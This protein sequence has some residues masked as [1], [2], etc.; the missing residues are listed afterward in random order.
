MDYANKTQAS[1]ALARFVCL[2]GLALPIF[3]I[4]SCTTSDVPAQKVA[5]FPVTLTIGLP[6]QTGQD[7]LYGASQA[8]RLLSREGLI[9]PSRDGRVQPRLAEQWTESADGLT[10]M[11]KLRANAFFHDG[12]PVEASDVKASLER[13]LKNSDRDLSPGLA[14]ITAIEVKESH[15]I[16]IRLA[17]RSTFLL[18]DLGV[19]I[20]KQT[21]NG[22]VATGPFTVQATSGTEVTMTAVP[23]HY[24]GK[25]SID[26]VVLKA[27][28]AV[29]TA[30]AAMMRGEVDFLY[31]VGPD[32]L[33]FIE[34]E[35]SVKVFPFLRNYVYALVFNS[36]RSFFANSRV[37]QALNFAVNRPTLVEHAFRGK[38]VAANGSAWPLHWAY[39]AS[40]PQY[41]Y[42]PSRA[43]AL[44]DAANVPSIQSHGVNSVPSRLRFVCLI[45]Q[46]FALWERMALLIQR[47][48]SKVGVDMQ[49][50]EVSFN[51]FNKRITEGSFDAVM[52]EMVAGNSI[53]RPYF[54]WHSGS[55]IN[56]W[57]Y[58]NE[59]VDRAL[60]EIRR[61]PTEA[62]YRAAFRQ[63]QLSQIEDPPAIFVALGNIA[64]AVSTRFQVIAPANSDIL[65]TI[66][67]WRL[68]E[69]P[70]R[71]AN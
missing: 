42:D 32:A 44:L 16:L 36:K 22:V 64:R 53:S 48:L 27:Y 20:T 38:G 45:P 65:P 8:T 30:W 13:S 23:N 66:S 19:A 29:R 31:E 25:P 62:S 26:R 17:A 7:P 2:L 63:F 60:D 69:V 24:R 10:W 37:R 43:T 12:T 46:N 35:L 34:P 14:D 61:S 28:P 57:G 6:V 40:I 4:S 49:L 47:D 15:E 59:S 50:E 33:E 39:D 41:T 1:L 54:F 11:F 55:R 52:M 56:T 3:A 68:V 51:D 70:T 67:D 21:P 18:D 5:P 71:A 9:L 58:K